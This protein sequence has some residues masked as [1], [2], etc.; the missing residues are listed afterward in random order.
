LFNWLSNANEVLT[1]PI[2]CES[3]H[4]VEQL[5]KAY[6]HVVSEKSNQTSKYEAL[7]SL[8]SEAASHGISDF[9]HHPI[10]SINKSWQQFQNDL[11]TRAAALSNERS[12]QEQN[13]T[14]RIEYANK[15]KNLKQFI[16]T[17]FGNVNNL[18]G[19]LEQQLKELQAIRPSI[20]EA[21]SDLSAVEDL[22]RKL[23]NGGV[24]E[25]KHT[26]IQFPNLKV[27]Y[28]QL[29]KAASQKEG[30]IQK[31]IL[32]KKGSS[33][34]A[35][36]LA[37]FREVF[38]HFDKDNSG[39]LGKLELRACLQSLGFAEED[40][41]IDRIIKEIGT[42]DKVKFDAFV[43]FMSTK[44]ADTDTKDQILEA[45]KVLAGNKDF[46]TEDDMKRALPAEKV[47]YLVKNMPL[48]KGSAGSYDYVAWAGSSFHQ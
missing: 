43:N 26:D 2:R 27:E 46:I 34:S 37:E 48:Y 30:I 3:V 11:E 31:E 19:D 8:A 12:K 21:S 1:D 35:E 42:G 28:E 45:F 23:I 10:D 47:Q 14:F 29:V 9:G 16:S 22:N 32:Q 15:A 17:K 41:A 25:N 4:D 38:N 24:T 44:T 18:P 36:Q 6:E 13:E 5:Q 20:T 40:A 39:N 7:V 33:V